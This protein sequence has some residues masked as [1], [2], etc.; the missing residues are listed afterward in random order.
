PTT[1]RDHTT[2]PDI[3]PTPP[4][5]PG[6]F[7]L[8]YT[9]SADGT[10]IS[11]GTGILTTRDGLWTFGASGGGGWQLMRNGVPVWVQGSQPV[12]IGSSTPGTTYVVTNVQVN[13]HGCLFFQTTDTVWHVW[14]G[15]Q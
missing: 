14:N 10:A 2:P 13:S 8:P 1:G 9:P 5:L 3:W 7:L 12:S 11:G 15:A 4:A 6:S